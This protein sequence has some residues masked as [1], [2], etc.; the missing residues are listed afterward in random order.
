MD[1][2]QNN[3]FTAIANYITPTV[4]NIE[5]TKDIGIYAILVSSKVIIVTF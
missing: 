5:V 2:V 1:K 4:G 3:A